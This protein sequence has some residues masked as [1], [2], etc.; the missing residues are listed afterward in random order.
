MEIYKGSGPI[1]P[2]MDEIR[3]I[4]HY[5]SGL[6]RELQARVSKNSKITRY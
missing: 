6:R 5:Q 1:N 4:S 2:T 3:Y